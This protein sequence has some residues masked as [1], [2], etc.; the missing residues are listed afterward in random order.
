MNLKPS[1]P[2]HYLKDPAEYFCTK[3]HG[4]N[5]EQGTPSVPTAETMRS[6]MSEEDTWPI[7]DIWYYH[8]LHDGQKDYIQAIET[9]YGVAKSL[10][11][12]CKKAQLINYDSHRAM[13]ESWNS[14][15]WNNTS[16]LLLWMTH[17]AWPTQFGKSILMTMKL[18]GILW[19]IPNYFS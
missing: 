13:F 6:M 12:F 15:L 18:L 9:K 5:T 19:L 3:A 8:D 14:R 1:G 10:D 2:W 7:G 16:G 17:P 11:D 4:F